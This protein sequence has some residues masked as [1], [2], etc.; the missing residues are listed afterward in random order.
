MKIQKKIYFAIYIFRVKSIRK[1][2]AKE[3]DGYQKRGEKRK[4]D[5]EN[6]EKYGTKKFG[7]YKFEEADLDLNLSDEITGNLRTMKVRKFYL[8][9]M[10]RFVFIRVK[11]IYFM[12]VL[13]HYKNEILSKHVFEQSIENCFGY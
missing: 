5:Y 9:E 2:I 1:E 10:I 11:V 13:N 6:K 12:I 3:T 7:R 4:I 8:Y